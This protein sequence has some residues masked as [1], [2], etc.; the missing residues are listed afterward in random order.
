MSI[1]IKEGELILI[2]KE[3][4]WTSFDVVNK[5]RY[6]IKKKF[7]IKKIKVGHAGTLDP[8]ATGLLIICCGKM[9]KSINN[10]SAMNKTYSGK[11]T[12]GST[13]PSYDLET[14]PN[15]H[16][17]IDHINEK[18]ILKTA[19]K[20]VG[21]IFQ[22]PPMFS[23]IKKDGVR[24]YNLARQGKEIKIDKREVSID[25]FEITSFNLPEISFNVTC[26]KGTYIRSLAH[27]FG[28]E[29]N[30]GAHLSELRRI[31]IGDYSVKDS[32]KVMDFIRGI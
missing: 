29:L 31:K 12:I 10:F 11:V 23:A 5:I 4:N 27:D 32:V 24:L 15:V 28:K 8:L 18:L 2:D 17:P 16:Y 22:T 19:K 14:K 3:L 26:S 9:T 30:S 21:K 20:F 7:D 13:T 25:S 1:N 6:A